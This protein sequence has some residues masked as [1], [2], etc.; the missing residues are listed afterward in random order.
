V[1]IDD[2]RSP[3]QTF[4]RSDFEPEPGD[5]DLPAAPRQV[6]WLRDLPARLISPGPAPDLKGLPWYRIPGDA[7]TDSVGRAAVLAFLRVYVHRRGAIRWEVEERRSA[8]GFSN[9]ISKRLLIRL[10]FR[11]VPGVERS[12]ECAELYPNDATAEDV[13]ISIARFEATLDSLAP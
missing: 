8:R 4:G 12:I 9:A 10:W 2:D 7:W 6:P 13:Q 5:A 1:T 11:V 3:H